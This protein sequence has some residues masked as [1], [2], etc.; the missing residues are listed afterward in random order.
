MNASILPS[1]DEQLH[2]LID[3]LSRLSGYTIGRSLSNA[4]VV[5]DG[6]V[7]SQHARLIECTPT[8][9]LLEDLSS[10][11]GT[12]VDGV[13]ITRKFVDQASEVRF[14]DAAFRLDQLLAQ[15][16]ERVSSGPVAPTIP[17]DRLPDTVAND[18]LDFTTEFA[19]LRLVYTQYPELR[20]ACR[21]RDKMIRTGSVILSSVVGISAV[22]ASGGMAL[23]LLHIMSGAGL[24]VLVPTLCSTFLS[25]DEKLEL[26][27]K[28]YR[29]RYRC[30]NPVCRDPFGVREWDMLAQQKTCRRCQA[31][32]VR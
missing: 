13:R 31:V 3:S 25:T 12:Y 23:S 6:R 2:Q 16:T 29:E 4:I 15:L 1:Q 14:A 5:A 28:E 17:A 21:Q 32:W 10:K 8:T 20:R 18:P 22:I 9:F 19:D 11:N 26:L 27:D 24:S 30:P 7:S